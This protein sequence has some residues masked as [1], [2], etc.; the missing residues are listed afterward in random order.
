MKIGFRKP[1]LKKSISART[2][3]KRVV[4][5][6]LG[7]KAPKGMGWFTDPKKS[8]YN[9]VYNRTT[10]S[11]LGVVIIAI[12]LISTAIIISSCQNEVKLTE[13]N[14]VETSV[15]ETMQAPSLSV[16]TP[17]SYGF[18]VMTATPGPTQTS[19]PTL[20]SRNIIESII[21]DVR[22][23]EYCNQELVPEIIKKFRLIDEAVSM[24]ESLEI[25]TVNITES[26][27]IADEEKRQTVIEEVKAVYLEAEA[28]KVPEC[29]KTAKMK[30]LLAYEEF[31]KVLER[32]DE[33][34][35]ADLFAAVS[36][37]QSGRNDLIRIEQCLPTGC[38]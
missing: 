21:D 30:I 13:L 19:V 38:K 6:N 4:R 3:L 9:R 36:I 25:G 28:I 12:V 37:G 8:A 18:V 34:W 1:S 24:E 11:C 35:F 2:S 16:E 7:V 33:N 31:Q 27:Y 17:D 23:N 22:L 29:L 32:N 15:A 10:R 20:E 5:H 26:Q 14:L